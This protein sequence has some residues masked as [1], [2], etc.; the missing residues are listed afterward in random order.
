MRVKDDYFEFL[1]KMI[2][3][4]VFYDR[5]FSL[6]FSREFYSPVEL[7]QNRAAYGLLLRTRYEDEENIPRG[8]LDDIGPCTVLEMLIALAEQIDTYGVSGMTDQ[9]RRSRFF[10]EMVANLGIVYSDFVY[11]NEIATECDHKIDIFLDR[12]YA[13]NGAGSLFPIQNCSTDMRKIEIW[14]QM[15][16]Y[17]L[18]KNGI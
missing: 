14:Y 13:E 1:E 12:K 5:L 4:S 10:W 7:D 6:L 18:E 2:D 11:T 9:E 15:Q 3:G 16:T 8:T 17:F